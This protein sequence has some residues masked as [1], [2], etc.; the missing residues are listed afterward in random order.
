MC[1]IE[2][3]CDLNKDTHANSHDLEI[4]IEAFG[5]REGDQK[6]NP[7]YDICK[8][9][10]SEGRIDI[11]DIVLLLREINKQDAIIEEIKKLLPEFE[12]YQ[13]GITFPPPKILPR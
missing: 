8:E 5:S 2:N 1:T 11:G 9:G 10:I 4:L 13:E 6:W 12:H 7:A 3:L